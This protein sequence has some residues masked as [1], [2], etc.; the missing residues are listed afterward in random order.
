MRNPSIWT[1]QEIKEWD[2]SVSMPN[3]NGNYIPARP[4]PFYGLR[5]FKNIKIAFAVF[6]GKYDALNWEDQ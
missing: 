2:A 1:A 5:F 4:L 6:T 3:K